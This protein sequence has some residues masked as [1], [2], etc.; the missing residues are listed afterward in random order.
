MILE[1]FALLLAATTAVSVVIVLILTF[2]EIVDWFTDRNDLKL[3][4][5][6]NIAFT[7][8]EKLETGDYKTVQGIFNKR[9]NTLKDA[10]KVQSN[11]IDKELKSLHKD[12]EIV[13]YE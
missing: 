3:E 13:I 11:K 2:L 12:N 5:E 7:L 9:T 8:Q 10:R 6:D 1:L 4:D